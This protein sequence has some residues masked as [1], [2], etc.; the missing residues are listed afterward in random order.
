M[1]DNK[2]KGVLKEYI[3]A[4]LA[5]IWQKIKKHPFKTLGGTGSILGGGFLLLGC[6]NT[7]TPPA[8]VEP[9]GD[10]ESGIP[11]GLP[12][13]L[14]PDII[15]SGNETTS[16]DEIDSGDIT[17]GDFES[18]NASESGEAGSG[19]VTPQLPTDISEFSD[20]QKL[21]L[22]NAIEENKATI[23]NRC[24]IVYASVSNTETIGYDIDLETNKITAL[25]KMTKNNENKYFTVE[26]EI[27]NISQ[28][29]DS[30]LLEIGTYSLKNS[31]IFKNVENKFS[32][33]AE[34]VYLFFNKVI[35]PENT[36]YTAYSIDAVP[37]FGAGHWPIVTTNAM[38]MVRGT[39]YFN[40]FD[41][42]TDGYGKF[43]KNSAGGARYEERGGF[44][45]TFGGE[46][47]I[48]TEM[49]VTMPIYTMQ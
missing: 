41:I 23:L 30:I 15:D 34:N 47:A 46:N 31:I 37:G 18:G 39:M 26:I 33:N 2:T 10:I 38:Y 14:I 24:G 48:W 40:S 17:S 7:N 13:G 32:S 27:N 6:T 43:T 25:Y 45:F 44:S 1:K 19:D 3:K 16:G 49:I 12:S 20:E 36:R 29:D 4:T 11:S 42:L 5:A 35:L 21:A 9:S 22:F 28:S 8:I